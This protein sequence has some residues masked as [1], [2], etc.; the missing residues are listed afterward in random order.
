[1][2]RVMNR[3]PAAEAQHFVPTAYGA[4][5]PWASRVD[6]R[7]ESAL[8]HILRTS[9]RL[10]RADVAAL[11]LYDPHRHRCRLVG[12]AS[13]D[14]RW[15]ESRSVIS[16]LPPEFAAEPNSISGGVVVLPD[17]DSQ[18]PVAALLARSGSVAVYVVLREE[19][20]GAIGILHV[21]RR[22]TPAFDARDRRL[23]RC[24]ADNAARLIASFAV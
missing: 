7:A 21:I 13:A 8:P 9:L 14:A 19:E 18:H 6:A 15:S 12:V 17:D 1:M 11:S 16:R 3:F 4:G 22:P 20:C 24:I 5:I 10:L 2:W 23:A